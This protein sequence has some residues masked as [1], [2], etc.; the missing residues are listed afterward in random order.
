MV[1]L[2]EAFVESTRALMGEERFRRYLAAFDEEP[3]VSIRLNP[4]KGLEWKVESGKRKEES[5][6]WKVESGEF[7]SAIGWCPLGYYL[8]ERPN[9]TFDPLLHAGCYYVQEAA[10]MFIHH[11]LTSPSIM[12]D[13][14]SPLTVLDLCAAPGGKST[15]AIAALKEDSRLWSNEPI[16]QRASILSENIQKWGYPSCIVTNN[17]PGD[18]VRSGL[19]FDIIIC[20][21]PCSGEGMFRKDPMTIGEWSSQ[22]VEKCW[23]LQREIVSDAWQCLKPGGL[24]IYSTCTFNTKENEENVRWMQET[25][26][27]EL[28]PVATLPEWNIMGSLLPGFDGPVYR[29][30]PGIT[31]SEGLFVCVLRKSGKGRVE[32]GKWKEERGEKKVERGKRKEERGKGLHVVFDGSGPLDEVVASCDLSYAD[33]IRYLRGEA[34][35]LPA[36]TPRGLVMVTFMGH[37]L[38]PVKNIGTRANN[39]Y[40][41]EWRIK[42]THIPT[43]YEAILRHT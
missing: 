37:P 17:Y 27:A 35:M 9:F 3:P 2:P 20:D 11:I 25:F 16:R 12:A 40:P 8:A 13:D 28:L 4:R 23:R 42:S 31:R 36:D 43:A 7:A 33:A 18:Y 24:L 38:G 39:L 32:S 30:I 29:F 22:N 14:P 19:M 1:T 15:C 10:S 34:I 5:G 41:K 6:E 26:D 21:V